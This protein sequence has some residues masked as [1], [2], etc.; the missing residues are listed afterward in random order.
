MGFSTVTTHL[1]MFIAV[2][3]MATGMI[4]V[5]KNY[6]DESSGAMTAQWNSMSETIKTDISITSAAWDNSSNTTTVYVLNTGKT[7]L[8]PDKTDIYIDG[9]FI[10]RSPSNRSIG[11]ENSTDTKNTGLWD[12]KEVLRIRVYKHL[13]SGMHTIDVATQFGVTDSETISVS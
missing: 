10:P 13:S 4:T 5:F 9:L 3:G 6:V 7:T 1:I 2:M 12:P 11:I 8:D